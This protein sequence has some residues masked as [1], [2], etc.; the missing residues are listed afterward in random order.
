MS[1]L[2]NLFESLQFDYIKNS[3]K[4]LIELSKKLK[5][6]SRSDD[7]ETKS[8]AQYEHFVC[9]TQLSYYFEKLNKYKNKS[10]SHK[11]KTNRYVLNKIKNIFE[12]QDKSILIFDTDSKEFNIYL[13]NKISDVSNTETFTIEVFDLTDNCTKTIKYANTMDN[14]VFDN[15]LLD[16]MIENVGSKKEFY[17]GDK[18][19]I[20]E[21]NKLYIKFILFENLLSLENEHKTKRE[22]LFKLISLINN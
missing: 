13:L 7:I 12:L 11:F 19:Y 8:I 6:K 22:Q 14:I 3:I 21:S 18:L 16:Y 17:I 4:D 1:N 20:N 2:H 15:R 10:N 5:L 9:A